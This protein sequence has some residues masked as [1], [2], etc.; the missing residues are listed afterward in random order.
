M[1]YIL[2][3]ITLIPFL[4]ILF[5][6]N[7]TSA[8]TKTF[9]KEYTYQASE[10]DSRNSSRTLALRE[11][12]RLLLEELG[13]Y[14][15]SL[16]EVQNFQLT[17]DQITTLTAGIVQ[18]EIIADKWDGDSLKYW[19]K[20]K[21]VADSDQVIKSIDSLRKDR[22]RTKELEKVRKQ[23]EDLLIENQRLRKVLSVATFDRKPQELAA[24]NKTIDALSAIEWYERGSAIAV[25]RPKDAIE[26]LNEAIKLNPQ[27]AKAYY[28]RGLAYA[29]LHNYQQEINDYNKAIEL[30]PEYADPYGSRG[31]RYADLGNY[32]QA[33]KDYSKV[34]ELNPRDPMAY[35]YRG[36][37]YSKLGNSKQAIKDYG[38]AIKID[39]KWADP[40]GNRGMAYAKLDNYRKA[41]RDY[42]KVIE[43]NTMSDLHSGYF[44]G[45]NAGDAYYY[46]G[47]VYAK[48]GNYRQ[49]FRDYDRSSSVDTYSDACYKKGMA[50]DKLGDHR[51]AIESYKIAAG[52]GHKEAQAYLRKRGIEW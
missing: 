19:L 21:I 51:R 5:I 32:Q 44:Y 16:T 38:E 33:I 20:T 31:M 45:G 8:E 37:A 35:C 7:L 30:D 50:F 23:A 27:F 15:E 2:I 29:N 17:K 39:P 13:T 25:S 28:D 24:Y 18:T 40:Y 3:R 42:T 41:I 10:D 12:K 6:P 14:L 34:I 26:A 48:L 36:I 1:K 47:I 11:V 46:R 43:L 4:I 52:L 22:T 9:I 49:A